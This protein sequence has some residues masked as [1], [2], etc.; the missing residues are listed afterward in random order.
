[1]HH[2]SIFHKQ[3]FITNTHSYTH[4]HIT[5]LVSNFDKQIFISERRHVNPAPVKISRLGKD[6]N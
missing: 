2:I 6:I 1:M 5:H 3:K 4:E